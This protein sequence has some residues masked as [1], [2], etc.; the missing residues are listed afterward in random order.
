MEDSQV[1]S[2]KPPRR[3]KAPV[4]LAG[5][6][7]LLQA[8][9]LFFLFPGVVT[10]DFL[11]RPEAHVAMFFD[12]AGRLRLPEVQMN[13]WREMDILFQF[14]DESVAISG[15]V[16][17]SAFFSLL[18][19][20]FLLIGIAFLANWRSAWFFAVFLQAVLLSMALLAYFN[21]NHPYVYLVM[22]FGI[23]MVFY[24]N[25]YEIQV[26]FQ[27]LRMSRLNHG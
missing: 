4:I 6:L 20:L 8:V 3:R 9:F 5:V 7:L 14:P 10:V 12:D 21:Y 27:T 16:F 19:G 24:L 26:A 17:S 1:V 25:Q 15:E 13:D 18:S 11:L 22:S 2:P 23:F